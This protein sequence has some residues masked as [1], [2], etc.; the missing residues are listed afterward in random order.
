MAS[1]SPPT[2]LVVSIISTD[3]K[4]RE[5][6]ARQTCFTSMPHPGAETPLGVSKYPK[7]PLP[8]SS[9]SSPPLTKWSSMA[10]MI[11]LN[12]NLA[13]LLMDAA[14]HSHSEQVARPTALMMMTTRNEP[15][16]VNR[17]RRGKYQ[18]RDGNFVLSRWDLPLGRQL[19][20]Y[21]SGGGC[22]RHVISRKL[23]NRSK[24]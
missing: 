9:S 23:C 17:Y 24:Y 2:C 19:Y 6:L 18:W 20:H 14:S 13:T 22:H 15:A 7:P 8:L 5:F 3:S 12:L 21:W 11:V 1:F 10:L 4:R 16:T